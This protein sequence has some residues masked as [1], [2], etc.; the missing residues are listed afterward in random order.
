MQV[1]IERVIRLSSD[2]T[3]FH[4]DC[5]CNHLITYAFYVLLTSHATLLLQ[6]ELCYHECHDGLRASYVAPARWVTTSLIPYLSDNAA[7]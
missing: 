4:Q 3:R 5:V 2:S 6:D 1:C 7:I